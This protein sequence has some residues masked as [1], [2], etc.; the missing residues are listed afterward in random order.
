[1][2]AQKHKTREN[3][4]NLLKRI[5]Q[6]QKSAPFVHFGLRL[7]S[8]LLLLL[9][10]EAN[11][12]ENNYSGFI[13]CFT[14]HIHFWYVMSYWSLKT[15]KWMLLLFFMWMET[16]YHRSFVTS[17]AWPSEALVYIFWLHDLFFSWMYIISNLTVWN[18]CNRQIHLW[19]QHR[20]AIY[21]NE[22]EEK[23]I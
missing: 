3:K 8:S 15:F 9:I 11:R 4:T 22:G 1:M 17:P 21:Q 6:F 23:E 13:L 19:F 16:G 5:Y 10:S 14:N 12:S 18:K 7:T 2:I 20:I